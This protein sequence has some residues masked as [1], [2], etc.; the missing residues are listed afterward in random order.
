MTDRDIARACQRHG[1]RGVYEA[2]CAF[3][4]GNGDAL[5]ELSL[6]GVVDPREAALIARIAFRLMSTGE[7][8]VEIAQALIDSA[9]RRAGTL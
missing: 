8:S 5:A 4:S 2:A 1:A 6:P 7:R 9:K 3:V